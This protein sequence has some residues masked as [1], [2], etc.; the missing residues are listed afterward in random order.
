MSP[1]SWA[2]VFGYGLIIFCAVITAYVILRNAEYL[3]RRG[4]AADAARG[5]GKV[6]PVA[7]PQTHALRLKPGIFIS[8]P[9][10]TA[11]HIINLHGWHQP[12]WQW[13]DGDYIELY[14]EGG[15]RTTRYKIE[16]VLAF[17]EQTGWFNV[18]ASFAPR[19][20]AAAIMAYAGLRKRA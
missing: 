2:A 11:L 16:E 4:K 17:H 12:A 14:L 9:N 3:R 6:A 13:R 1:H 8:I 20:S 19:S 15:E 5:A 10:S 7:K 18:R